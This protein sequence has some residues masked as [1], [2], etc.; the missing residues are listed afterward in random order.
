MYLMCTLFANPNMLLTWDPYMVYHGDPIYSIFY[1]YM[2][3]C[4]WLGSYE[5]WKQAK[6]DGRNSRQIWESYY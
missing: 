2:I 3:I 4:G 6:M 1:I 5:I